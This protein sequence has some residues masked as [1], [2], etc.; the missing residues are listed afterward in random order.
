MTEKL[1]DSKSAQGACSDKL[2]AMNS[3]NF[4]NFTVCTL[5]IFKVVFSTET[6]GKIKADAIPIQI[7]GESGF[8]LGWGY[9]PSEA[10]ASKP[11]YK[12]F[13]N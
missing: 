8:Q 6:G 10:K 9:L 7:T 12:K 4:Q 2:F 11:S 3:L 5:V 13:K 1:V